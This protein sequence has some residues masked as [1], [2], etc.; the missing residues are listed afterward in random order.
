MTEPKTIL[1]VNNLKIHFPI[2]SGFVKK[3]T[4]HV[5]AVDDVTLN[6]YEKKNP[7]ISR[8]KWLW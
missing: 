6:L 7:R 1:K 4:G 8:R 2:R 3:I 5:R